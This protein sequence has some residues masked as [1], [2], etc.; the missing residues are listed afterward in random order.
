MKKSFVVLS[1]LLFVALSAKAADAAIYYLVGTMNDWTTSASYQ[2]VKN[3]AQ[4]GFEE[5][6]IT[7]DLAQNAEF[8]ALK[9]KQGEETEDTWY[10]GGAAPNYGKDNKITEAGK[11]D[12]YFR[13]DGGGDAAWYYGVLYVEKATTTSIDAVV[14]AKTQSRKVMMNGTMYILRDGVYYNTNGAEVK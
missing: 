3:E 4:T 6:K 5:Y 12:I 13:P 8:K 9:L 7:V 2:F 10:P 11:Y 14:G 1:M